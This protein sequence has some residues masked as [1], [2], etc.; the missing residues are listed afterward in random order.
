MMKFHENR[1]SKKAEDSD[2]DFKNNCL[3]C[4]K[5]A[6]VKVE[7]KKAQKYR[8][9]VH[10]V[11][12]LKALQNIKKKAEQRQDAEGKAVLTRIICAIDLVAVEARYHNACYEKKTLEGQGKMFMAISIKLVESC[13]KPPST[14]SSIVDGGFLMHA[15]KSF[16]PCEAVLF[17]RYTCALSTE[18]VEGQRGVLSRMSATITLDENMVAKTEQALQRT[19]GWGRRYTYLLNCNKCMSVIGS[20]TDLPTIRIERGIEETSLYFLRS[21][22]TNY[23]EKCYNINKT[24]E[25]IEPIK[26]ALLFLHAAT[27]C[28][29]TSAIFR[30]GKSAAFKLIEQN[31]KLSFLISHF[32]SPQVDPQ[33][34]IE[35]GEVFLKHLFGGKEINSPDDLRY[36]HAETEKVK[37][38]GKRRGKKEGKERGKGKRER[39][40]KGKS[41]EPRTPSSQ[42]LVSADGSHQSSVHCFPHSRQSP[43]P[44]PGDPV[45]T[46]GSP[47]AH[48]TEKPNE[49]FDATPLKNKQKLPPFLKRCGF[50]PFRY[51]KEMA[52][53]DFGSLNQSV[54]A[55]LLGPSITICLANG[56]EWNR[57]VSGVISRKQRPVSYGLALQHPLPP[58]QAA[59]P[60]P[61]VT[62]RPASSIFITPSTTSSISLNNADCTS[63]Q[64]SARASCCPPCRIPRRRRNTAQ[65]LPELSLDRPDLSNRG[66]PQVH[67][68]RNRPAQSVDRGL[69]H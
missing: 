13:V 36:I 62:Q 6:S 2:F 69:P 10:Y 25:A 26:D 18:S 12:T 39:D 40:H 54:V 68:C 33:K 44:V 31:H 50:T 15:V 48:D 57:R 60:P 27:G 5:E 16:S 64:K 41:S 61:T 63:P 3:F 9:I 24:Q 52:L 21:Q 19:S 55:V 58:S 38:S 22:L 20:D 37:E 4:D 59:R 65:H 56:Y 1:I 45:W 28:D 14:Y 46:Q 17:N 32:N 43:L 34:V 8:K 49:I 11:E 23:E 47:E 66:Q 30:K 29:T 42:L 35:I 53:R 7:I 51:E 67:L